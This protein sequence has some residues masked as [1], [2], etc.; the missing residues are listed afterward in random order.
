MASARQQLTASRETEKFPP[1]WALYDG[2]EQEG[3]QASHQ[4]E[5]A[6]PGGWAPSSPV[7]R[8]GRPARRSARLDRQLDGAAYCGG[9]LARTGEGMAMNE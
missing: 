2:D 5:S 1:K 7:E 3:E 4:S 8:I 6:R 9:I